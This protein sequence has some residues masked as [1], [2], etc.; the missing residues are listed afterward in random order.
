[1]RRIDNKEQKRI[2]LNI[3]VE[4]MEF[5]DKNGIICMLDAGTLL[6]A[7]RHKGFIPWD[8]DI[9]VCILR[10]DYDK[11]MGIL[12][13][14]NFC[15]ND[16]LIAELPENSLFPFL[17][18]SDTR[19]KLIEYPQ[20]LRTECYAYVDV[21]PKDGICD[22]GIKGKYICN[23]SHIFALMHW[24]ERYS[25]PYWKKSGPFYKKLIATVYE[26]TVLKVISPLNSQDRFIR[27]YQK[28]HPINTCKYVTTLV[29]GEYNL[30]TPLEC[31]TDSV[32]L[33]FEGYKFNAPA[34][35]DTWLT[36]KY[37]SDYMKLPPEDKREIHDVE[38][39]VLDK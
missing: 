26:N 9:D 11:L 39:Y 27:K 19:T 6:G 37:G 10:P 25:V 32:E 34:G 3:L 14:N 4:F 38:C 7:V 30:L 36:I 31:F 18:V 23:K 12:K 35:Y 28:H 22:K 13:K 29:I 1:M 21:F 8:N 15:I 5:C 33:D 16:H 2:M 20:T 24:T 17:K